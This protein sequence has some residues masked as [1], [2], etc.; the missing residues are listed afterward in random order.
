MEL[1]FRNRMIAL[2]GS[3]RMLRK[4]SRILMKTTLL[5]LLATLSAAPSLCAEEAPVSALKTYQNELSLCR[6]EHGGGHDLPD[7]RF[8]LFGMGARTKLI[9]HDG[10]LIEATTG[11]QLRHWNTRREIIV[12]CD[13]QIWLETTDG[14]HVV[15]RED[16]AAVWLEEGG[17]RTAL[18]GTRSAV[19]L[20]DFIGKKYP[21]VLRVL[22]HELLINVIPA[23]PVPN[24]FVYSKP[25]YRD[26]AMLA[27]ALKETGNVNLLREWIL[28]LREPFDHNSG[29]FEPD[30]LGQVLF[31][32]SLVSDKNHPI[33]A[34]I[35]AEVSRFEFSDTS[36]KFIRGRTDY[37]EHPAY[38][39]K[40]LKFGLKSLGL[41]DTY[42]VPK[43]Q[44]SYSAL[45]W[46]DYRDTYVPGTDAINR[47][48]Y[49]YLGWACDHF[50]G[51]KS[52]PL[53]SGDYPLTWET[54]SS[55]AHYDGIK[56][57]APAFCQ[58]KVCAPHTW[59]AA[60]AFLLLLTENAP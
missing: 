32:V 10:S 24:F 9:Y 8:F 2:A 40:W 14:E 11:R 43:I 6:K 44:D 37:D 15:L 59:H 51:T 34:R 29:E 36:G 45:F 49:P 7:V 54:N 53:G 16:Q 58:Q 50:H 21:R 12:P 47:K 42:T 18:E 38:Q 28:G 19:R 46:M 27:L 5:L 26:S 22:H 57:L 3:S 25:W 55:Q 1:E 23:G 33:V 31:L 48:D 13:Y 60:E 35:L 56:L 39:T 41:P 30:N 4:Q 52:C 17:K 20:P